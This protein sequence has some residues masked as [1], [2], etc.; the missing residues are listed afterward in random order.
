MFP[1]PMKSCLFPHLPLGHNHFFSAFEMTLTEGNRLEKK[2][3]Y[4][5]FA[6]VSERRGGRTRGPA[7]ERAGEVPVGLR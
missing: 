3:F 6:T 4:A 1:V 7:R 2:L 5:T